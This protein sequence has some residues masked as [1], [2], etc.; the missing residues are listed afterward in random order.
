MSE[1]AN[2]IVRRGQLKGQLTHIA[3]YIRDNKGSPDIDQITVR[4]EKTTETWHEFQQVQ[5]QIEEETETT[6][7]SEKY[8]SEFEEFNDEANGHA[9]LQP[10]QSAIKLAAIE[11]PR[12]TGVY[13]E[14]AAFYDIYMALIHDNKL[15]SDIQKFF[16]L[17]SCLSGDAKKVID[18]L[19][20][21]TE[22]YQV[23]WTSLIMRYDNKRVLIQ[24][25]V[26][27]LFDL[28]PLKKESAV[29]LHTLIDTVSGH[30][31][32]LES[33]GQTPD[34]WGVLLSHLITSKLDAN[35]RRAWESEAT[36][37]EDFIV[38][39][40][41]D[42]LKSRF[43]ILEVIESNKNMNTQVPTDIPRFKKSGD[44]SSSFTT[45]TS[46]RCY[47]CNG[48]HSIYKCTKFLALTILERIKR[49][50]DL[51][52]C[53]ICLRAHS[54][55]CK[56]RNCPKCA[57]PHNGL[58]SSRTNNN[59]IHT[60][61]AGN[62]G[63][64]SN[65]TPPAENDRN[66]I[67]N[68]AMINSAPASVNAHARQNSEAGQVLLSTAEILVF[69]SQ[70]KPVLC[71]ALLDSGS[72]HNFMTESLTR[73]L[74]LK[75]IKSS[76]SIIGINDASHTSTYKVTT[77][78]K[79]RIYDYSLNLEFFALPNLTS[80]LPLM[81]VN[82]TELKV[83]VDIRLADPSFH[84]PKKVDIILGAEIYF[85]LLTKEQIQTVSRGPIFQG[86]RLGWVIAGPI[87]SP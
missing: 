63:E 76:C 67:A 33:L 34:S 35:T 54:D 42:F 2:I 14:W 83:P 22:N 11:I 3:N 44:R 24:V 45:T 46:F 85:E 71:R 29:H 56:S 59:N 4:L 26:K 50:N 79:S 37:M 61:G 80:K 81:P 10:V 55:K 40:L 12:F 17:R 13:T 70:N 74:N 8:R 9:S 82:L 60:G 69:D 64:S 75:R 30:L 62:S 28:Q 49:I 6:N 1:L 43:R 38:P 16:Y 65:T 36:K 84:V 58:H 41:I 19:Q 23:A 51:K 52:L 53:N 48:P 72:Q 7:E 57:R 86:T 21:T 18:C 77:T 31:K 20:T 15:M 25:R 27:A 5:A 87:P 47:N 66:D 73:R 39:I 68:E 32:A 78:I